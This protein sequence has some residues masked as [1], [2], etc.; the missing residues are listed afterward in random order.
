MPATISGSPG[1]NFALGGNSAGLSATTRIS[2]TLKRDK[3]ELRGYAGGV[4]AVAYYNP[5][6][7][8]S[9][10]GY[11]TVSASVGGSIQVAGAPSGIGTTIIV[12]EITYD[13]SNDDFVK[14]SVKAIGY[15]FSD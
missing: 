5:T 11:G 10:E 14:S 2:F 9:V 13:Q 1:C 15:T 4:K 8:I 7:D 3:K 12:E 6:T